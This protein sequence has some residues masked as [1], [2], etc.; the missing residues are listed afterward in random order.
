MFHPRKKSPFNLKKH[1]QRQE[2]IPNTLQPDKRDPYRRPDSNKGEG[3]NLTTP[4]SEGS[5]LGPAD[6]S[7]N[8]LGQNKRYSPLGAPLTG[9]TSVEDT[10]DNKYDGTN[11]LP[12]DKWESEGP[13]SNQVNKRENAPTGAVTDNG[14]IGYGDNLDSGTGN[15]AGFDSSPLG[16]HES[17][18]RKMDG[19]ADEKNPF[20]S[21]RN[22]NMFSRVRRRIR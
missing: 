2:G 9:I 19:T 3:K 8:S 22:G 11:E 21:I 20:N 1:S 15:V 6:M 17:V 18:Q 13:F 10:A 14:L 7:S 4:G 5:V 12:D 16:V